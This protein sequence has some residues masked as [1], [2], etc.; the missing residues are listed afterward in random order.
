MHDEVLIAEVSELKPDF[1]ED[2]VNKIVAFLK[3]EGTFNT[4]YRFTD[5]ETHEYVEDVLDGVDNVEVIPDLHLS[6]E[7]S[8]NKKGYIVLEEEE[9]IDMATQNILGRLEKFKPEFIACYI[10]IHDHEA[11]SAICKTSNANEVMRL[12]LDS[13][14][15]LG[16]FIKD[17]LEEFGRGSFIPWHDELEHKEMV[18]EASYYIYRMW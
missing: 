16:L 11:I 14:G 6:M 12:L 9:A 10:P 2:Q 3:F 5:Q 13:E 4:G 7:I 18:D 15:N 17:A 1:N 8:Y